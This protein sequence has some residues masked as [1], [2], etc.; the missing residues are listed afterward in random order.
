MSF[1]LQDHKKTLNDKQIDKI[2]AKLQDGFKKQF[3]AE[4]R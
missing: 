1:V 4:L 2:M 3:G